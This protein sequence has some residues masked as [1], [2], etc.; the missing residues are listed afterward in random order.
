MAP[1]EALHLAESL[2]PRLPYNVPI[3]TPQNLVIHVEHR[4]IDLWRPLRSPKHEHDLRLVFTQQ[5]RSREEARQRLS[6][7]CAALEDGHADGVPVD[8]APAFGEESHGSVE[9][10]ENAAGE[11]SE[12][13]GGGSRIG[14][15]VLY[16][17]GEAEH[18]RSEAGR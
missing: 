6:L 13:A 11:G 18:E 3:F 15:L 8:G 7:G 1:D 2:R 5:P 9:G 12:K 4:H 16:H 10:E 14:V 17:E